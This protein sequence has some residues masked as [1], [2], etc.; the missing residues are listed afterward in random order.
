MKAA[1]IAAWP[2]ECGGLVIDG[3]FVSFPN[4]AA[5]PQDFF[6][7]PDNAWPVDGRVV[8]GVLHS[9]CSPKHGIEPSAEDMK[10]QMSTGVPWG[11]VLTTNEH[12]SD[13]VWFGDHLLDEP[14]IGRHYLHGVRDCYSVIRGYYWQER[15]IKLLD[16]PREDNWWMNGQSLYLDG[17]GTTGFRQIRQADAMVGDV[18]LIALRSGVPNHAAVVLSNNL[19]L[20]HPQNRLSVREPIVSWLPTITTWLRHGD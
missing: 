17:F 15:K 9:H 16:F 10:C 5:E 14:L 20:H 4:V 19:M 11:I 2:N 8:D 13:T 7:L 18:A 12:C 3:K 1:A 6:R